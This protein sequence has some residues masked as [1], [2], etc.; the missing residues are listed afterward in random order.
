V[1]VAGRSRRTAA[2]SVAISA[3]LTVTGG[4]PPKI[5]SPPLPSPAFVGLPY[6]HQ[7]TVTG[8]APVVVTA[9]GCRPGCP[10]TMRRAA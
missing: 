4:I 8:T 3:T 5:T 10:T 2:A 6:L 7:V 1:Q 9:E